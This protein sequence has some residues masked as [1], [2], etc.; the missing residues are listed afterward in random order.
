MTA[1]YALMWSGGKDSALAL[2]RARLAGLDVTRLISFYEVATSRVRFHAT[3]VEMLHA[4]A[5]AMGVELKAIGT[6]WPDMEAR[7]KEELELLKAEAFSGV[8]LGDIHLA[9]V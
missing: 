5:D 7:L 6:T 4:Q 3:P 8:V 2:R 1:R 9:D